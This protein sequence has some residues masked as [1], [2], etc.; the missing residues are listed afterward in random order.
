[1]YEGC[2]D[3]RKEGRTQENEIRKERHLEGRKT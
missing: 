2:E 3:G 1:M